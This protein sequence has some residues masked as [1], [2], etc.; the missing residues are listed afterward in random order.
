MLFISYTTNNLDPDKNSDPDA[1]ARFQAVAKAYKILGDPKLR[2]TY[3]L[4]G[5]QGQLSF[6]L[7]Y[8]ISI[9]SEYSCGYD[10]S[11]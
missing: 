7:Y 1:T 4:L 8:N 6:V 5:S 9:Y 10:R 3:D 2:S 11:I